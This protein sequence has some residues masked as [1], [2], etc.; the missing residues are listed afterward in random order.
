MLYEV[1]T[2]HFEGVDTTVMKNGYYEVLDSGEITCLL[3]HTS[4]IT[5]KDSHKVYNLG[6]QRFLKKNSS[7]Y[8]I[9]KKKEFI[10]LFPKQV[11]SIKGKLN[12]YSYNFV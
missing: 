6:V 8:I 9:N 10:A 5:Y 12:S 1:I 7:Y 4:K 3:Q 11:K 2:L